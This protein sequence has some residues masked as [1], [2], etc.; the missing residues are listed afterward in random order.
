LN[1]T[2]VLLQIYG[3]YKKEYPD[4]KISEKVLKAHIRAEKGELK[5][6]DSDDASGK[7]SLQPSEMLEK[8]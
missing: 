3:E 1:S 6:G 5:T 7:V 4:C 8:I 2:A